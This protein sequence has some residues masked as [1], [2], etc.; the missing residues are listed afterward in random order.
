MIKFLI[1]GAGMIGRVHAEAL[2]SLGIPFSVCDYNESFAKSLMEDTGAEA[3]Y[4]DYKK[5][6]E[7]SGAQAAIICTPNHLHADPAI[8]AMEHGLDV[9]CEKPM[10]SK[11]EDAK[12]IFEAQQRTGRKLMVG[13]PVRQNPA[14]DFVKGLMN[15]ERL[16]R[17]IS[18]RCILAAPAT[19][20]EAR[21]PYRNAYE[22]GG[23]IIYDYT[24]E[25][26]YCRYLLGEPDMV[27]AFCES[28]L[29]RELTVDDSADML[30]H[31]PDHVVLSLHMDY[32]QWKGR[33][34]GGRSFEL[35]FEKGMVA[36]DFKTVTIS[37]YDGTTEKK[38]FDFAW[39]D[40]FPIQI[41]KMID[42]IGGK[43]IPYVTAGDGMRILEIADKSYESARTKQFV[44]L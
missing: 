36:C 31:F 20:I 29:N 27:C 18:A 1:I 9:I 21:T 26:D 5:A 12:R 38:D 3:Y 40:P 8:Y 10:A 23:G 4:L 13:Y 32:V 43:E 28:H 15:D 16:G 35:V 39:G 44:K 24:H 19:L 6:I 7:K 37:F 2:K 42:I 41:R 34:G 14:L 11:L 22:T 25:I 17:I 30:F 33:A